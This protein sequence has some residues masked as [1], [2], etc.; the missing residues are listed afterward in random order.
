[1]ENLTQKILHAPGLLDGNWRVYGKQEGCHAEN[2]ILTTEDCWAAAENLQFE[3]LDLRFRARAPESAPQVDIWA[4]F[5]HFNRDYRYMV[6]LRGGNHKHLYLARL[7]ALGHDKM[8]ALCPLPWSAMPGVWYSIRVV[9]AGSTIAVYLNDDEKPLILCQDPDAPFRSGCIALG[10]GYVA[11]EYKDVSITEVAADA[12][13][14]AEKQPDF[15]DLVTLPP[16]LREMTRRRER[17][18]YRPYGVP[19]LPQTRQELSLDGKWLFI[20]DYEV[21]DDPSGILYDDSNAHTMTVPA[22]WV[23]LLAW[24]DGETMGNNLNKGMSDNYHLEEYAR[25]MNQTFDYEHTN[26]AWYRHYIDLPHG[27][28]KKRVVLDFEGISLIS[29][30]YCNGV[31]VH[32]NIGMFTPMQVDISDQVHEGRNVIA[33]AVQRRLP[34]TDSNFLESDSIDNNYAKAREE[35]DPNAKA[36]ATDCIHREFCTED[37]PHGFYSNNPGGIW[38]SVRLV[39]SQ[40][41][42]VEECWFRPSL[43]DASIEV[44]YAN[45]AEAAADITLAYS[46]VH[47]TT[48]EFL[49]GGNVETVSMA[50]GEKRVMKFQTPPVSPRLWGPGTPNLYCLTLTLL[51]HGN[52]IDTYREQVGFRTVRFEG[53]TMIYNGHPIW[54]RGGN[55]MPAHVKPTDSELARTYISAALEHN[56][57]ATRTHVAPWSSQWLDA[58]DEGGL[59][60]SLEGTWPWLMISH[61][62]SNQSLEIWKK[63]LRQLFHR[64]RNRPSLFLVTLN[65]EM[66]FYLIGGSDESVKEKGYLAQGGL[67]VAREELPDLPLVCDSGYFRGPTTQH[68]RYKPLAVANGRYERIIQ[69]NHFDD[70]DMDDPHFY[71]GWYE[72][73]FFHFMNGEFGRD[74]TLPGRPCMSQECSVGY[75]RAEDGHAARSYLFDQQTPQTTTGKRAYEHNDPRYFQHHHAFQI[76]GLVEMFRRVEHERTC[77]VLLFAFETWFYHHHDSRRIQPMLS[78]KRL[79]IAYQ[80]VLASAELFGRHFYAGKTLQTNVT[81]I[82]DNSRY[83]TLHAPIVEAQLI[84]DGEILAKTDL[85]YDDIPYFQTLSMPLSLQIPSQLPQHRTEAKL[86]LKVLEAAGNL[87]SVNDYEVLLADQDWATPAGVPEK[88]RYL[89]DDEA[90]QHLLEQY[91]LPAVL[92][93]DLSALTG[94]ARRLVIG[95]TLSEEEAAAVRKFAEA[96]GKAVLLNQ[97]ALPSALLNGKSAAYTPENMEIMTM[98]IPES[99]LFAGIDELDTAWFSNGRDVPYVAYGRYTIDRMDPSLCA[100]GETLQWHNYIAKPTDYIKIGGTP[101][102]SLRAGTGAIL[103]SCLRTDVNDLDPVASRLTGNILTWDFD[104]A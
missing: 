51:H 18:V 43:Q 44:T 56:L 28:E 6:G 13:E 49:C 78:A 95:R 55:H 23:P 35:A 1:M 14:K 71:F 45:G 87:I 97:Q 21:K 81:V 79:K 96:G 83:E 92:C 76:Q 54:V 9:C 16:E 25:C 46:L 39:I 64:N 68:G 65:N 89:S 86:V 53:S 24:L 73:S 11:A 8:L 12:L 84:A 63:E 22:S 34:D 48:G 10:G 50:A 42:H 91:R 82:N 17:A 67:R 102:F 41:L 27:I 37:L 36:P 88:I 31:R 3:N 2:G 75:C 5:R 59:M 104:E 4:C 20:P 103:I 38:R 85:C 99:T 60:I 58:A 61:I 26:A 47:K 74:I 30:I 98:N 57:M 62:P 15:L 29:S 72:P 80:P 70:G 90:A 100:L 77:G 94:Q 93:S 32:E 7:G 19:I 40:K 52:V 101:L 33:V 66:N 69:P